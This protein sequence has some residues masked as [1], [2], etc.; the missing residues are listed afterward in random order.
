MATAIVN[1]SNLESFKRIQYIEQFSSLT[2]DQ[3]SRKVN[4][5][6]NDVMKGR[7]ENGMN[8]NN[9]YPLFYRAN[10]DNRGQ[11]RPSVIY[12]YDI[13]IQSNNPN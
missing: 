1:N 3:V 10:K 8:I 7:M 11:Y 5:F 12:Q 4:K 13:L 9:Q 2:L 6:I